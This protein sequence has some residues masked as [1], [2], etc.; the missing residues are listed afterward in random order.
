[1]GPGGLGR[2][3]QNSQAPPS[4]PLPTADSITQYL[5]LR[6]VLTVPLLHMTRGM[7]PAREDRG[8]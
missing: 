7:S 1:M 6:G 8:A 5:L 4:L 3:G 2:E